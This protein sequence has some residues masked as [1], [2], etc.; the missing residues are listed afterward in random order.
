MRCIYSQDALADLRDLSERI[1]AHDPAAA[2]RMLNRI[3]E[4]IAALQTFPD[5]SRTTDRLGVRVFAGSKRQPYRIVFRVRP[6][7]LEILRVWH[8]ARDRRR[9][10]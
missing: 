4:T 7:A 2:D 5:I 9:P 10:F 6:N 8:H 3:E 1:T